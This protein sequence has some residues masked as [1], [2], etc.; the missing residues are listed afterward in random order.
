M[1]YLSSESNTE[2]R[3]LDIEKLYEQLVNYMHN[4]VH[5][6]YR[7]GY[8][9]YIQNNTARF[10]N[11]NSNLQIFRNTKDRYTLSMA[12]TDSVNI[13]KPHSLLEII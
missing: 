2:E 9:V 8:S 12:Q 13:F 7:D 3:N 6:N 1:K 4:L 10:L 11:I 5:H